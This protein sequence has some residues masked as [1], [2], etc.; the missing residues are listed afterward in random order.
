MR[1]DSG[2]FEEGLSAF[3]EERQLAYVVVAR[4]TPRLKRQAAGLAQWQPVDEH[5]AVGEF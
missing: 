2:F 5:Y 4:L 3:L 1:A